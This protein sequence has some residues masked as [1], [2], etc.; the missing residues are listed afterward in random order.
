MPH[1][2]MGKT[3]QN[4]NRPKVSESP[5]QAGV[6]LP[7]PAVTLVS[8]VGC[9]L[10]NPVYLTVLATQVAVTI[11]SVCGHDKGPRRKISRKPRSGILRDHTPTVSIPKEF[12][13]MR[14]SEPYGDIGR[15]A[16]MT[17]PPSE[18]RALGG[19]TSNRDSFRICLSEIPCRVRHHLPLERAIS[20]V[21]PAN[22]GESLS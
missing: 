7:L 2:D 6:P 19:S 17:D 4:Y 12:E 16:E 14:W 15:S 3:V 21:N 1:S 10:E 8:A 20:R 18:R 5:L 22:N 11:R 13:M 9:L